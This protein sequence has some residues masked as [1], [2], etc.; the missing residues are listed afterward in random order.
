MYPQL[1][2]VVDIMNHWYGNLWSRVGEMP[3]DYVIFDLETS[4]FGRWDYVTQFGYV[5]VENREVVEKNATYINVLEDPQCDAG[6]MANRLATTR[7]SCAE[8]GVEYHTTMELLEAGKSP[9]RVWGK[10]WD[11][12]DGSLAKGYMSAGFNGI[13]YDIPRVK[14][15]FERYLGP[16][17]FDWKEDEFFDVAAVVKGAQM[18]ERALPKPGETLMA[19]ATRVI[20]AR[21]PGIKWG[22]SSYATEAFGLVETFDL[23]MSKA[24]TADFDCLLVHLLMQVIRNWSDTV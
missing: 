20:N 13:R 4:G 2:A 19:W 17:D 10:V 21:E 24:H 23:D 1:A 16:H 7:A 11:L 9:E 14:D 18:G 6:W 15:A 22:L 5:I 12:L 3:D 8:S